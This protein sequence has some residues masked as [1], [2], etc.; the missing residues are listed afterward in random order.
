MGA[1]DPWGSTD[2]FRERQHREKMQRYQNP[3][4]PPGTYSG[5]SSSGDGATGLVGCL[6]IIAAIVFVVIAWTSGGV[7]SL[8][9]GIFSNFDHSSSQP[10]APVADGSESPQSLTQAFI[11]D[12]VGSG[13]YKACAWMMTPDARTQFVAVEV[14]PNNICDP[15]AISALHKKISNEWGYSFFKMTKVTQN[16]NTWQVDACHLQWPL[17]TPPGPQFGNFEIRESV[18][19]PKSFVITRFSAC[20]A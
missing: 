17:S 14:G 5:G 15:D 12:V 11:E 6:V 8:L 13:G 10:A 9:S 20:S 19:R 2:S 18:D 7:S 16:G 3:T 1:S 4:N